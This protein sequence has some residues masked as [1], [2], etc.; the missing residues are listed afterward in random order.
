VLEECVHIDRV[1]I[2][3]RHA[4]LLEVFEKPLHVPPSSATRRLRLPVT[5]P[6]R[7]DELG[8][9]V[10]VGG[11]GGWLRYMKSSNGSQEVERGQ[12]EKA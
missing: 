7:I 10:I 11:P 5:L 8:D 1:D 12:A 9:V 6:L 3:E 4:S 2:S